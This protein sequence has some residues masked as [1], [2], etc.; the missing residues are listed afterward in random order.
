M[1]I[2][3]FGRESMKFDISLPLIALFVY[4]SKETSEKTAWN[5]ILTETLSARLCDK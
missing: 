4:A 1:N 3:L 5:L 2:Q